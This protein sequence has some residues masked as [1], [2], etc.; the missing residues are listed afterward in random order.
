MDM[1]KP[2]AAPDAEMAALHS[3]MRTQR[4]QDFIF[5]KV[6]LLFAL[7]VLLVLLGI[8]VSLVVGA[9]PAFHGKRVAGGAAK[10]ASLS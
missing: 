8:I 7:S 9:A 2:A 3:T 10:I 6:T 5:H 1:I 4:I